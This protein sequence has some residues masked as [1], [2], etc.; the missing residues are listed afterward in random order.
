MASRCWRVCASAGIA[1][2]LSSLSFAIAADVL[3][4]LGVSLQDAKDSFFNAFA[5][6]APSLPD[7][8]TGVRSPKASFK[9]ATPNNRALI[10]SAVCRLAKVYVQSDEFRTRYAEFRRASKPVRSEPQAEDAAQ[11]RELEKAIREAEAEM[12]H[13]PPDLQ[14]ELRE[15]IAELRASLDPYALDLKEFESRYP[16]DPNALVAARLRQFL[17][18]SATIDYD[19]RLVQQS[20]TMRFADE[21]LEANSS[22]WKFCYRAGREATDAAR[23]FAAQWLKELGR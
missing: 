6:G 23:A 7:G 21:R 17:A 14:K 8:S 12:K 9:A 1:V 22:D 15:Q 3:S 2:A 20:G 16:E 11:R 19:A 10:V 18:L 13:V 5:H 4:D